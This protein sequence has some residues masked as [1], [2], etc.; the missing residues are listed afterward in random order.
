MDYEE[1]KRQLGKAGLTGREFADLLQLNRNSISNLA[2][3]D[4]VPNHYA[5]IATLMGEMAEHK[6]DFRPILERLELKKNE[7][8]G[9]GF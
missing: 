9:K 1:F 2:Q 6:I 8:R 4:Q 7:P 5:V 3:K